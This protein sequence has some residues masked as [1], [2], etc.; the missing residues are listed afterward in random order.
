TRLDIGF[1]EARALTLAAI[2]L[3]PSEALAPADAVARIAA[4]DLVARIDCPGATLS[5]RDGFAVCSQS[6]REA[7]PE[8]PVRLKVTAEAV[9][10]QVAEVR[11]EAGGAVRI[12]TGALLPAGADAVL[13]SEFAS[14]EGSSVLCL[15][16]AGPGRNLLRRGSEVAAGELLLSA[17]S[18]VTPA[19]AGLAAASGLDEI[20]VMRRPRVGLLATG[21]EVVAPGRP[22]RPGEVYAS[23][24]VTLLGWLRHAGMEGETLVAGDAPESIATAAATL[25]SRVDVLLTSGGAWKSARDLTPSVLQQMGW[26][27]SYHRVRMGPGKAVAFGLM[28]AKP[29]FC[30]PGGPASNEMAFLQ[31]ALPALRRM[32]GLDPSPLP[33]TTCVLAEPVTGEPDWTQFFPVRLTGATQ[34]PSAHPMALRNRLR[35]RA[36]AT[37]LLCLPEGSDRLEAGA[38]VQVQL[39]PCSATG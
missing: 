5:A 36:E 32:S 33:V 38:T 12:T 11:L 39:L 4:E 21:D 9:A 14:D 28:G 35:A 23:N 2:R 13:S 7:S 26:C 37:G 25:L 34:L 16:D 30:L 1:E 15:R 10:G 29:C 22:L 31:L 19:V 8:R 17:G 27:P 20:R 6:L 24:L 3:L 18:R